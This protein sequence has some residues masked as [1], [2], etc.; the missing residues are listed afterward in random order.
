MNGAAVSCKDQLTSEG[1]TLTL[2]CDK[3]RRATPSRVTCKKIDNVLKWDSLPKC[4]FVWGGFGGWSRCSKT[5]DGGVKYSYRPCLGTNNVDDCKRDQ[6]GLN[7][8]TSSCET[9]VSC[10]DQY[11]KFISVPM[12]DAS[13]KVGFVTEIMIVRTMMTKTDIDVLTTFDPVT[14]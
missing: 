13:K 6:G 12:V 9:Q 7:Y 5:C 10:S 4:K 14:L 3:E 8:K 2:K 1:M 11:G